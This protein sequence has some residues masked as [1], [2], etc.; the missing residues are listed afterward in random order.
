M[1]EVRKDLRSFFPLPRGEGQ[2]EGQT[3]TA[4]L[5][6][7][8]IIALVAMLFVVSCRN[9]GTK[10]FAVRGVVEELK[11]DGKTA[12]IK[13]E[14]IPNY[15]D[16]MTMQFRAK[17][18]NELSAVR[19][20]DE[21]SFR[22]LVTGDESWI[23]RVTKTGRT[24]TVASFPLPRGEGQGE[25]QT[26][27][28]RPHPLM[29]YSFTNQLGLAVTLS[30]FRGQALAITFFFTRCPIPEYCPRLTKNFE[31]ASAKLTARP[32][33]PT[34]WHL[35]SVT[36]DP[37][38]DTPAALRNYAKRYQH[39]PR[40]WSFL[41]GPEDKITELAK[42]SGVTFT[43]DRGVFDHNFRTLIIGTNGQLQ[44]SFPI[45]GNI[46]D[47]IVTELLKALSGSG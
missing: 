27:T 4:W 34:N 7:R 5:A 2:G 45:G 26:S 14:T 22:L 31:E 15:M 8:F 43:P 16:A 37:K 38:F 24:K 39:D 25:G 28:N 44:M 6:A 18:T 35:L 12:I 46:S 42:E 19:P 17:D 10:T 11:P 36:I 1:S 23:D 33:A 29:D 20:G 13:H 3:R 30:S 40:H 32:N 21:I 47:G 9:T 41:T